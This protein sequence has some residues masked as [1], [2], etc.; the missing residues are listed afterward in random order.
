TVVGT[1]Y[2]GEVAGGDGADRDRRT[3]AVMREP[4]LAVRARVVTLNPGMEPAAADPAGFEGDR[5]VPCESDGVEKR[6]DVIVAIVGVMFAVIHPADDTALVQE[7]R[8]FPE[9]YRTA[10]R[11]TRR[12]DANGKLI[13]AVVPDFE[14]VDG[15]VRGVSDEG[16]RM[17][18]PGRDRATGVRT[19]T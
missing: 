13:R 4:C 14:F 9:T 18:F 8:S 16:E 10:S 5:P 3:A 11:I 7:I 12:I 19:P 15:E 1:D 2:Q 6:D 17:C